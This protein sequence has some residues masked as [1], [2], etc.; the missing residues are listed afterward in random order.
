MARTCFIISTIGS[1]GSPERELAN[2][3]FDYLFKPILDEL[4]YEPLRA[5]KE[6][7]PGSISRKIV[8]RIIHSEIVIADVSDQNPNVFYEL[9]VRNATNKPVILIKTPDQRPPFDIQDT[10]AISVDMS[11]PKIWH[12]AKE[13][14]KKQIQ[15]AEKN[16]KQASESILSDFTFQIDVKKKEGVEL[17]ILSR[18]KDL[19]GYVRHL[20]PPPVPHEIPSLRDWSMSF[21]SVSGADK[22]E[23]KEKQI[24]YLIACKHCNSIFKIQISNRI[25]T[26]KPL[27]IN[28]RCTTCGIPNECNKDD[29]REF[30]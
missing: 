29:L 4:G 25:D 5:D 21:Q 8:E 7:A 17:E 30:V 20:T 19:E 1:E 10:R 22:P 11:K 2:E 24:N 15:E 28:F 9:A 26:S 14:L 18:I 13:Q 12:S 27:S 23:W 16:P 3:K 6:D